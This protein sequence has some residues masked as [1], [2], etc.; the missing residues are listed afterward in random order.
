[1]IL[2]T[3]P[4]SFRAY[5][6]VVSWIKSLLFCSHLGLQGAAPE[7]GHLLSIY[8]LGEAE[9]GL[10][11]SLSKQPGRPGIH[12]PPASNP[13]TF[14]Y[15]PEKSTGIPSCL[16]TG[17]PSRPLVEIQRYV[18]GAWELEGVIAAGAHSR[19]RPGALLRMQGY[20]QTVSAQPAGDLHPDLLWMLT[21]LL[22]IPHSYLPLLTSLA[23]EQQTPPPCHHWLYSYFPIPCMYP[24]TSG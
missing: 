7:S 11:Q 22:W 4:T 6:P 13:A 1:M 15:Y 2:G 21:P 19:E 14:Y 24:R 12:N 9:E 10:R 17:R 23:K 18:S 5:R 3:S 8:L 16:R 20:I